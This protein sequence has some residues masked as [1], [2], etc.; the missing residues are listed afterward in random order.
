MQK[1]TLSRCVKL[2]LLILL[3]IVIYAIPAESVFNGKSICVFTNVFGVECWGC[4]IT[5]AVFSALYFRFAEAWEYNRLVVIVLPLLIFEWLKTIIKLSKL[6]Y[7][8]AK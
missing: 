5:R 2:L 6:L 4:G 7:D 3:P 8:K 1:E